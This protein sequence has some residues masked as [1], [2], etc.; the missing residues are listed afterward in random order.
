MKRYSP[1]DVTAVKTYSIK[2]RN[3]K[4]NVEEHFG[5]PISAGMSSSAL[6]DAL[7]SFLARDDSLATICLAFALMSKSVSRDAAKGHRR[8]HCHS[9]HSSC[10]P[11]LSKEA[12]IGPLSLFVM[13]W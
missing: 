3:N 11:I 13:C 8:K 6:L 1:I 12:A 4:V 9:G 7:E 10:L 2:T 5:K